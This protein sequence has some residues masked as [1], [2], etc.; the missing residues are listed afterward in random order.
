[1]RDPHPRSRLRSRYSRALHP[2]DPLAGHLA[3]RRPPFAW[4]KVTSGITLSTPALGSPH[5]IAATEVHHSLKGQMGRTLCGA[6]GR[7][8]TVCHSH[9]QVVFRH[10]TTDVPP[11]MTLARQELREWDSAASYLGM[12]K[13]Q[14]GLPRVTIRRIH[15]TLSTLFRYDPMLV[16]LQTLRSAQTLFSTHLLVRVHFDHIRGEFASADFALEHDVDFV[17]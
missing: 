3:H 8:I 13:G 15:S 1:M 10:S 9:R 6:M 14:G 17:V 11:A 16:Y 2:C 4:S 5:H 12:Q 7:V